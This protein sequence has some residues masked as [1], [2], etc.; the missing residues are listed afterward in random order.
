MTGGQGALT[1]ETA[2]ATEAADPR[3]AASRTA[4]WTAPRQAR[5]GG[6]ARRA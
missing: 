4:V 6:G 5:D 3:A 1:L 2:A